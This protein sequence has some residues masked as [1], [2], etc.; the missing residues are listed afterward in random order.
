M[1]FFYNV[2]ATTEIY[3]LSL[4]DTLPIFIYP[5]INKETLKKTLPYLTYVTIYN[6]RT[7][8]YGEIMSYFDDSE[9]IQVSKE[10]GTIP[11][12]MVTSLSLEGYPDIDIAKSILSSNESQENQAN[13][14]LNILKSKG[15]LG[16]N[17]IFDYLTASNLIQHQNLITYL[18]KRIKSEGYLFFLTINTNL[19]YAN[20]KLPYEEIDYTTINKL[21]TNITFL[22]F[23]WGVNYGPPEPGNSIDT[24][25][26]FTNYIITKIPPDTVAIGY[27]LIS[28]D[29][30]LPYIPVK[31]YA[32]ALSINSALNTARMEKSRI[33]FDDISQSPFFTYRLYDYGNESSHIVWTIDAR[34]IS[35]LIKLIS[36][37]EVTGT[38]LWNLMFY[39]PQL[40]LVINSQLEIEKLLPD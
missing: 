3:T 24:L 11:L 18:S 19:K 39:F 16:I 21:V 34:S 30:E 26:I 32:N 1:N 10:Y 28:Y 37:K 17:F 13:N 38:C 40:W 15:Y 35:A 6:Y 31:S 23:I 8:K 25:R 12:M 33:Q 14:L 29:W 27:S 5:Y 9:I 36:E 20:S 22:Q 2:T 4:H 7:T